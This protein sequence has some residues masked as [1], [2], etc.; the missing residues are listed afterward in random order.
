VDG[1][2]GRGEVLVGL[3]LEVARDGHVYVCRG[4][5]EAV[6]EVV[7]PGRV[8]PVRRRGGGFGFCRDCADWCSGI[9]RVVWL[10]GVEVAAV[11]PSQRYTRPHFQMDARA[12]GSWQRS[13]R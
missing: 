8:E 5:R 2:G 11:G 3:E 6:E 9:R 7:D 10:V 12:L 13:N 1:R 4:A